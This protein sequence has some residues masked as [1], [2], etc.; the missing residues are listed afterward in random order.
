MNEWF[1]AEGNRRSGPVTTDE[2]VALFRQGRL[3]LDTLVWRQ[4]LPDW[5][6]LGSVAG[7]LGLAAGPR[8]GG[9]DTVTPPPVPSIPP[10]PAPVPP[11]AMAMPPMHPARKGLSGCALTA[12][13]G[14]VLLLV[15]I[16][17]CAILAAIALPAYNDYMIR[18]KVSEAIVAL[19]PLKS[20]VEEFSAQHHRCPASTDP[21]F[22]ARGQ[23]TGHGLS[24]VQLGTFENHH[25]GIEATLAIGKA[26]V[27]GDL[28]WLEFDPDAGGWTCSGETGDRY[29]PTACRD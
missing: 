7:E 8:Q 27:D 1:H 5:Q 21:G 29:L 11:A 17:V 23:F 13:I 19:Q 22:P 15:M 12:I 9:I 25:C 14:G 6:P 24:S 26:K 20:R 4:G 3:T 16:P 18:A 10:E 2:L 28:L